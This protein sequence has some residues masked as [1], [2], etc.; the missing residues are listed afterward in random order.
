MAK[1][2]IVV[3]GAGP[4]GYVAAVRAAQ[5]G[6]K[7]TIVEE[8]KF[9]GTCINAG[10]IT[11]KFFLHAAEVYCSIQ[12]GHEYG[13]DTSGTTIDLVKMQSRKKMTIS[14][15]AAGIEGLLKRN[16]IE[17][18]K[19]RGALRSPKHVEVDTGRDGKQMLDT[20]AIFVATGSSSSDLT[21]RG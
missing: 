8:A 2:D 3:I 16:G 17:V 11:T 19:G 5:L 12:T 6:A 10:C 13:I 18:I 4:A 9:G 15:L 14:I 1:R 20:E 21:S 7:V